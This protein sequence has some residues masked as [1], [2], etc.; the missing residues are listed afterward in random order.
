MSTHKLANIS[1]SKKFVSTPNIDF[2][3][4]G[5]NPSKWTQLTFIISIQRTDSSQSF[6]QQVLWIQNN[7][8]LRQKTRRCEIVWESVRKLEILR[9]RHYATRKQCG[10]NCW[11]DT[12]RVTY[13][14]NQ[15]K[16]ST[17]ESHITIRFSFCEV[18]MTPR[19]AMQRL[20]I[21]R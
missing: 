15:W 6:N 16:T 20:V 4:K 12:T 2:I 18:Y 1:I 13:F 10:G 8:I 9:S 3:Y 19:R 5:Q 21:F 11:V 17:F 14:I 7:G